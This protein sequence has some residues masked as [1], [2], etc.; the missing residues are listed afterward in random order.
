MIKGIVAGFAYV[1]ILIVGCFGWYQVG[2]HDA[3]RWYAKHPEKYKV[4]CTLTNSPSGQIAH[5]E[6]YGWAGAQFD[7]LGCG[8][9]VEDLGR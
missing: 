9:K 1:L 8:V 2:K 3:D 4:T 5:W 7:Y 6:A